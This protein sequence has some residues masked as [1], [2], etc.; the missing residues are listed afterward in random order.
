[1]DIVLKCSC[2][3]RTLNNE[4]N[5]TM[6]RLDLPWR[7]M[8]NPFTTN[9]IATHVGRASEIFTGDRICDTKYNYLIGKLKFRIVL[10]G[11][12]LDSICGYFVIK[13]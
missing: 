1:M 8:T 12:D 11:D 3:R 5:N 9:I 7:E 4:M 10:I 2:C 13:L 6:V